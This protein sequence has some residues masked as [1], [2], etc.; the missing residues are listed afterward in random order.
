VRSVEL[1]ND[2]AFGR[3]FVSHMAFAK[4]EG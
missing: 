3:R 2:E 1:S 4:A